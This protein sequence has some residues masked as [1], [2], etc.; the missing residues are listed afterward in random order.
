MHNNST[1]YVYSSCTEMH[2][3]TLEKKLPWVWEGARAPYGSTPTSGPNMGM[4]F[5]ILDKQFKT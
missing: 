2:L 3:H 1:R 4:Q 5:S